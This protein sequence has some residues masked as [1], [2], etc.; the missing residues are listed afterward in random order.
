MRKLLLIW[1][2]LLVL[3]A[4]FFQSCEIGIPDID[5]NAVTAE[6]A[7]Q[8]YLNNGDASYNWELKNQMK[9]SGVTCYEI[10][11]TSQTWHNIHWTHYMVIIIPDNLTYKNALLIINGGDNNNEIP[12]SQDLMNGPI[13]DAGIMASNNK[14]VIALLWQVPNQPLFGLSEDALISKTLSNYLTDNDYTWPLL[15]PMTKSAIKA[16]DLIQEFSQDKLN[17]QIDGFVVTGASKRGWTTWLTGANDKRVI[18]IAPMVIDM[19]NWNVNIKYQ[20]EVWGDY[21]AEIQDYVKL[22]ISQTLET[23]KGADIVKMID[24]YSYRKSL[25]MPKMI[26]MGT[27]DPYWPVDAVK[28]YI[29]DIPGNNHLCYIPNAD[30]NLG[31][32]ITAITTLNGFFNVILTEST[33][34]KCNYQI[35]EVDGK[36]IL[37]II[38]TPELL[39]DAFLWSTT[40]VGDQDFRDDKWSMVTL[41]AS[42]K[43]KIYVIIDYPQSGYKS[44]YVDLKYKAPNGNDYTQSTRIFVAHDK[45]VLLRAK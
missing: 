30:H 5:T 33:N 32:M 6:T 31:D 12:Y 24:P 43:P 29:D 10:Q 1:F 15:F 18:G 22:G 4:P 7:L 37:T 25:T 26:F 23:S 9:G 40:S 3:C 28:N 20:K 13:K 35:E 39:V 36:I 45:K 2:Y 16:M 11:F 17:K 14:A 27:N 42:K 21:S 8:A 41:N 38:T 19:L 44:F 34:P